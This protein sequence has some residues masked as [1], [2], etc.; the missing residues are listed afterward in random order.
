MNTGR[1]GKYEGVRTVQP[2]DTLK[3]DASQ[4]PCKAGPD[5]VGSEIT[6]ERAGNNRD[7]GEEIPEKN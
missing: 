1:V 3:S 5:T 7:D 6:V 4:L 2:P